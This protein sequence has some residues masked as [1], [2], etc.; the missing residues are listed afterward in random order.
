MVLS[1]SNS[2]A[3]LSPAILS[4]MLSKRINNAGR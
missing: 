4:N 1:V 3:P 2:I